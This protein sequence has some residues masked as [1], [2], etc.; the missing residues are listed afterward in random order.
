MRRCFL[1][2]LTPSGPATGHPGVSLASPPEARVLAA[3]VL[4]AR[5]LA[6]R[7]LAARVLAACVPAPLV[8][9]RVCALAGCLR[10]PC[11]ARGVPSP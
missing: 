7:V 11:C 6:A 5:V 8:S 10:D 9:P 1:G 4:A 3:R 2:A